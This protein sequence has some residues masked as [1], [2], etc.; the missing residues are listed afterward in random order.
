MV[1]IKEINSILI[2]HF[3]AQILKYLK[4]FYIIKIFEFYNKLFDYILKTSEADKMRIN[5]EIS[6]IK[7]PRI[8]KYQMREYE[9]TNESIEKLIFIA[10][11]LCCTLISIFNLGMV[12]FLQFLNES[13]ASYLTFNL[14]FMVMI[15]FLSFILDFYNFYLLVRGNTIINFNLEL[16]FKIL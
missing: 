1:S 9:V 8:E 16:F 3:I 4:F 6:Y 10:N 15:F 5:I 2:I 7:I 12:I 14:I 11:E 13:Q